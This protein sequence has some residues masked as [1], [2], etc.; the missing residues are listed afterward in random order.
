M[1][2]AL[3]NP[4]VFAVVLAFVTALLTYLLSTVTDKDSTRNK[5]A[6]FATMA[7]GLL[8]GV[9]LTYFTGSKAGGADAA[10]LATEPFDTIAGATTVPVGI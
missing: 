8:A 5:R 9:A 2:G 10:A 1:I 6:F 4:Y 7:A 3:Q